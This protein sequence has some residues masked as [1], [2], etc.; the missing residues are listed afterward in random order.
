MSEIKKECILSSFPA[1]ETSLKLVRKR[2]M[3]SRGVLRPVS[4]MLFVLLL[5]A[6]A[7]TLRDE[8]AAQGNLTP[9]VTRIRISRVKNAQSMT[10]PACEC[11]LSSYR[12]LQFN[13]PPLPN[14]LLIYYLIYC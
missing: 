2:R 8:R 1:L 6:R 11:L 3:S 14:V 13:P 5:Q 12:T 10:E 4:V 7:V 9:R